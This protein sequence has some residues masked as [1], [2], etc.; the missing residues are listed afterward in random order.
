MPHA[1]PR[2]D[3]ADSLDKT[4]NA[5]HYQVHRMKIAKTQVCMV[6]IVLKRNP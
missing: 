5:L 6:L 1:V 2:R 3:L 4:R